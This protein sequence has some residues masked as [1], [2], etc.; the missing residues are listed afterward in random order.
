MSA[1][2]IQLSN[3]R[4]STIRSPQGIVFPQ[5]YR[6]TGY[7]FKLLEGAEL[8]HGFIKD[9]GDTVP[10]LDEPTEPAYTLGMQFAGGKIAHPKWEPI[11]LLSPGIDSGI[12]YVRHHMTEALLDAYMDALFDI[13][14][15][16]LMDKASG[17]RCELGN[18]SLVHRPASKGGIDHA[19][20]YVAKTLDERAGQIDWYHVVDSTG[21]VIDI[22]DLMDPENVANFDPIKKA[23]EAY[24][25][26]K[27]LDDL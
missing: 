27:T 16:I 22:D 21:N 2:I 17:Y 23:F 5:L 13:E 10:N 1:K 12:V 8:H 9:D 14:F 15:D 3:T 20:V 11:N 19:I 18:F 26:G 7:H 25:A 24:E 6:L 4:R